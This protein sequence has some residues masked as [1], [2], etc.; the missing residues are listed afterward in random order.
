MGSKFFMG[1]A[2]LAAAGSV[3]GADRLSVSH[4]GSA[5]ATTEKGSLLIFSNS[6]GTIHISNDYP[7]DVQLQAYVVD[8]YSCDYYDMGF[9][10]TANQITAFDFGDLAGPFY[11]GAGAGGGCISM[12]V[13]A[14]NSSNEQIRWNHLSGGVIGDG[15]YASAAVMQGNNG[16]TVGVAGTINMDGVEYSSAF[17]GAVYNFEA[18]ADILSIELL[19]KDF[20]DKNADS[21]STKVV[22]EIWNSDEVKFSGTS[23]CVSC[24]S[25]T[26]LED[27]SDSAVNFFRGGNLGTDFGKARLSTEANGSCGDDSAEHAFLAGALNGSVAG[28]GSR[29]ATI[30]YGL[31]S[32]PEEAGKVRKAFGLL[33]K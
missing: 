7:A 17:N 29:S 12:Y 19:D 9:S 8:E 27:W 5:G 21:A 24:S 31:E 4:P 28:T 20:S 6:Y 3:F 30:T 15:V 23:R 26:G 10:L 2:A 16:D 14:V 11:E 18:G 33:R 13:W 32:E 22:A 25:L 1:V